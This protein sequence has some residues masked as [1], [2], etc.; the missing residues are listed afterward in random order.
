MN[1]TTLKAFPLIPGE[2]V[3]LFYQLPAQYM[4]K[5]IESTRGIELINFRKLA[6]LWAK[7]LE[8]ILDESDENFS[9]VYHL[10]IRFFLG[11]I[12]MF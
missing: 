2:L 10:L 7:E 8:K 12:I 9:L 11:F 3:D 6:K 4:H 1:D 5:F